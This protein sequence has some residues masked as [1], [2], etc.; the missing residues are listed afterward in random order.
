MVPLALYNISSLY[1]VSLY[2]NEL[3]G[4]LPAN[5]GFTLPKL[6]SFYI[7][8]N[9]FSGSFPPSITNASELVIFSIYDNNIAGPNEFGTPS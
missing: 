8:K 1:L 9:R 5:L 7:G 4:R 2:E 3:E 6:R